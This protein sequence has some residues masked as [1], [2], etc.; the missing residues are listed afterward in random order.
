VRF[1]FSLFSFLLLSSCVPFPLALQNG[2]CVLDDQVL[3][4]YHLEGAWKTETDENGEFE[5]IYFEAPSL[6]FKSLESSRVSVTTPDEKTIYAILSHRMCKIHWNDGAPDAA[7]EVGA[8]D[9]L[10]NERA[11]AQQVLSVVDGKVDLGLLG[12]TADYVTY[13]FTGGCGSTKLT[14][15]GSLDGG[16]GTQTKTYSLYQTD[17]A[18]IEGVCSN[19]SSN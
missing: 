15:S 13:T 5:M 14:L 4:T 16:S 1:L 6:W 7:I 8:Y 3:N 18:V 19:T 11:I 2:N 10:N 9:I 17:P 12:E